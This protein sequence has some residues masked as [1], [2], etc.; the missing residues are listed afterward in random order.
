MLVVA[1]LTAAAFWCDD[2]PNATIWILRLASSSVAILCSALILKLHFRADLARDYLRAIA[3]KYFNRDGFCL[4]LDVVAIDGIA[5]LTVLYQNQYDCPCRGHIA[6]RP[7]RGFWMTR[8]EIQTIGMEIDC[9]AAGFGVARSPLPLLREVQGKRQSFQ[10]GASVE[11]APGS[12]R[13]VRFRDGVSLRANSDFGNAFATTAF[14]AGAP[15][16]KIIIISPATTT[17]ALPSGVAEEVFQD[18]RVEV[19]TLWRLGDPPLA[20]VQEQTRVL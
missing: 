1:A 16:G 11:Y 19:K 17:L 15:C 7:A 13:R 9:D 8:S 4:A 3:G 10:V 12:R 20:D 6:V 2:Q 18:D 14:V 5:Y